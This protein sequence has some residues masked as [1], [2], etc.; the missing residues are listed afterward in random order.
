M[1][2]KDS[3]TSFASMFVGTLGFTISIICIL[4][5]FVSGFAIDYIDDRIEVFYQ[6]NEESKNS[7]V[8]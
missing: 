7:E 5:F 8:M 4:G 6:D 2:D 1:A 3:G